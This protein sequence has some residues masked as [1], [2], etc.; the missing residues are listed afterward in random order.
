MTFGHDD[1]QISPTP[2]LTRRELRERERTAE[3]NQPVPGP[4]G[5]RRSGPRTTRRHPRPLRRSCGRQH[6]RAA[7]PGG[8]GRAPGL[9]PD[10]RRRRRLPAPR[11]PPGHSAVRRSRPTRASRPAPSGSPGPIG[12]RLLSVG[13][14]VF[15]GALAFG[16]SVPANAFYTP[17]SALAADHTRPPPR[18]CRASRWPRTSRAQRRPRDNWS[19]A[20]LGRRCSR[21]ATAPA[22]STTR[23]AWAPSA[24]RSRSRC[25]SVPDSASASLRVAAAR[26]TT[27]ASTSTPGN[28][29]AIFAI[30]DGVVTTSQDDQ[31]GF[32]NHVIITHHDQRPHG[33]LDL[34]PH[35]ARTSPAQRRRRGQG[36]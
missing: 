19:R 7:R 12:S 21:S 36:R 22:T 23:S 29:A 11:H 8:I 5:G 16:M 30:A 3:A 6:L 17:S 9:H 26:A 2:A 24:G 4:S 32:G 31:W 15:A 28:G 10:R 1:P 20:L 33:H 25:R 34:R 14:L 27:W 35:A 18:R 13:A